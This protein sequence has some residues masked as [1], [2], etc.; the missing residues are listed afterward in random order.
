MRLFECFFGGTNWFRFWLIVDGVLSIAKYQRQTFPEQLIRAIRA[1][2]GVIIV[3]IGI[4][5]N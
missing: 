1:T 5:G 2:A 3:F 4:V